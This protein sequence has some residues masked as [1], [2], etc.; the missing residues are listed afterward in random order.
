MQEV[1]HKINYNPAEV[2]FT[3]VLT[4]YSTEYN[5]S[6]FIQVLS[7]ELMMEKKDIIVFFL[8]IQNK[9]DDEEVLE[10]FEQYDIS[11]LDVNRIFRYI[12][13]YFS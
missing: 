4:K 8:E 9:L 7:Q 11:K 2:R 6:L 3:K 1:K 10:L 13:V 5:N 12:S